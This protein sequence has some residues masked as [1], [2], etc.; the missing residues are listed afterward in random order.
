MPAPTSDGR[1]LCACNCTYAVSADGI[2]AVD[3]DD[4][5][6]DGAGFL[7]APTTFVG[8]RDFIDACLVG[9]T[10]DGVVLAF[11]GTQPFN[12][13]RYPTLVDWLGD[14]DANP[15]AVAGYPGFVHPGF[16]GAVAVLWERVVAEV[17]RQWLGAAASA[18]LL[19]T[20]HS[21]GGAMAALAAWRLVTELKIPTRVVTFAAPRTGSAAFRDAYSATVL[22]HSRYEN[23][24]DIV[25]LL[26][27]ATDGFLKVLS[28]LPLIGKDFA[29]LSRFDYESVG[30][31]SFIDWSG[32]MLVGDSP[33][34]ALERTLSVVR[35]IVRGRFMQI[36]ADHTLGCGS[37]YQK[38]I[39]PVGVCS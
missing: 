21:K 16:S 24:D 13:H 19:V 38:A 4:A 25:P 39:C 9:T 8:G 28:A 36:A 35:L 33:K 31:L 5:F 7:A 22:D 37:G 26:P 10:V 1:L 15:V 3:A 6:A 32:D 27:A 18:P 14:F 23:A 11:R 2:L 20:G 29:G 34:L 17:Q 12:I 30:N